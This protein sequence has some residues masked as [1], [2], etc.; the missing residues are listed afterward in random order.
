MYVYVPMMKENES[1]KEMKKRISEA[2]KI[3]RKNGAKIERI[4]DCHR[5]YNVQRTA[6]TV[7]CLT[8]YFTVK[9]MKSISTSTPISSHQI[10]ILLSV[11]Y[12][13]Y[14]VDGSLI[15]FACPDTIHT[16]NFNEID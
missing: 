1:K 5:V 9:Q 2:N 4:T 12:S 16:I 3:E 14:V 8:Q 13:C 15:H 6:Y 10:C 7:Q 11:I